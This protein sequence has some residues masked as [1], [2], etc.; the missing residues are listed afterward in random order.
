MGHLSVHPC[1]GPLVRSSFVSRSSDVSDTNIFVGAC[2]SPPGPVQL[3]AATFIIV[4]SER[5]FVYV[6]FHFHL[7]RRRRCRRGSALI[8]SRPRRS[9]G[10]LAAHSAKAPALQSSVGEGE[11]VY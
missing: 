1:V 10:R 3:G 2:I 7:D 9:V 6:V 8:G 4:S 11:A 5:G